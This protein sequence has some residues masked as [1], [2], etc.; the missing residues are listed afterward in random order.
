MAIIVGTVTQSHFSV[1]L[2]EG[3]KVSMTQDDKAFND[4]REEPQRAPAPSHLSGVPP[5]GMLGSQH[6]AEN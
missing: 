1:F 6:L 2:G 4:E 5:H 3:R